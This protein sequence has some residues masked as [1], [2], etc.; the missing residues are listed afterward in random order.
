VMAGK[1]GEH[2]CSESA[3]ALTSRHTKPPPPPP[4]NLCANDVCT[5]QQGRTTRPEAFNF[6]SSFGRFGMTQPTCKL[7]AALIWFVYGSPGAH[8]LPA[9]RHPEKTL[10]TGP[11][12]VPGSNETP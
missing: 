10:V 7:W 9:A 4:K 8:T 3:A 11:W 12:R 6:Q 5:P 2:A 1:L